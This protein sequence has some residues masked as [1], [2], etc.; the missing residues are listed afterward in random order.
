MFSSCFSLTCY[1]LALK[2]I[3]TSSSTLEIY[4]QNLQIITK[5]FYGKLYPFN[6][7]YTNGLL[8]LYPLKKLENLL[9]ELQKEPQREKCPNTEFFL[10]GP[11]FSVFGSENT[12]CLDTFP[13]VRPQNELGCCENT[14]LLYNY[15][16]KFSLQSFSSNTC[17]MKQGITNAFQRLIIF[18][19]KFN[20]I[21]LKGS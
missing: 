17:L 7:F 9:Q 16:T 14:K 20:H 4:I 3:Y 18:E 11:Y 12:P 6:P 19:K 15:F 21:C 8:Y 5:Q 1:L 2:A 13:T 10:S